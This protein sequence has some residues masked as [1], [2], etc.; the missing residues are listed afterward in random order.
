MENI[1]FLYDMHLYLKTFT[2]YLSN[3]VGSPIEKKIT[4]YIIPTKAGR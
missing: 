3:M 4:R 2:S 1:T